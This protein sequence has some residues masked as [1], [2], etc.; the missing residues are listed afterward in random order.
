MADREFVFNQ[1]AVQK[2]IRDKFVPLAMDDWYLRRQQ[3][4]N[5]KFFLKMTEQSPR[6]G[7]GSSTRQGRYVFTA[8]GTF[9]G[10]NN[11]RG[12]DR[13]LRMLNE[14]L[15]KWDKLPQASRAPGGTIADAPREST[16]HRPL[17]KGGAV[18]KVF[19]RV[20]ESG[21]DG[22]L[23]RCESAPDAD[24]GFQHRGL[25]AAV[26]HLWLRAEDVAALLPPA[27]APA[28]KPI[29]LSPALAMRI[30]RFHLV[31]NTR[32]EPP[33]WN[34]AEVRT[35]SLAVVPGSAGG[36]RLEGEVHLETKDGKRGFTGKLSGR[37][38]YAKGKLTEFEAVVSGDHWGESAY[39]RGARPG[40]MPI[41]FGFQ[42][43]TDPK[44]AD[45][46]PPQ[47]ARWLDGYYEADR[48]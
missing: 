44:P 46:I 9:L 5:G 45:R 3:D 39:T 26:D 33:Q 43:V 19:T 31:D 27:T 34:R 6:G 11:N 8:A 16:Y 12:P 10:F 30:A 25:G 22:K 18:I 28:G 14:S 38:G 40:R 20:L 4:E 15:A 7:A 29:P 42:L 23:T 24:G 37:F 2:V 21:P 36:A 35:M 48:H 13:L 1:P 32:G 47:G 41:G 17:P